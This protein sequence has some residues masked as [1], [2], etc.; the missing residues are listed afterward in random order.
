MEENASKYS[1]DLV[2]DDEKLSRIVLSPRDIDPVT[3]YPKDSF[4]GLRQ[5]EEGISFLR[6]DFIGEELFRKRGLQ[7]AALYNSN[8]K[9]KKY[10]F[11]G[12]MEGIVKE[13]KSLAPNQ[14]NIMVNEPDKNP[15]HVNIVFN[16][17]GNLVK[18]IVTDAE[19][20]DII[21]DLFHSLK[22]IEI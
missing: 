12:W 14:I 10:S 18:G 19:I 21:D 9:K 7:R 3:N 22:F 17:N 2:N 4:I 5:D 8:N 6:F 15:E 13:I 1:P 16:K 11:V 20:L